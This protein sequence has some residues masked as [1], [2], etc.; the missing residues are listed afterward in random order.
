M[1]D[2]RGDDPTTS[3]TTRIDASCAA[4]ACC[5]RGSITGIPASRTRWTL[6]RPRSK[7]ND[8]RPPRRHYMITPATRSAARSACR[9][10]APAGLFVRC[11][12]RRLLSL[13]AHARHRGA[14]VGSRPEG[15]RPREV[16][17]LPRRRL[18]S[19]SL[20]ADVSQSGFSADDRARRG[21]DARLIARFSP[22]EIRRLAGLGQW[23]DPGRRRLPDR[24]PARAQRRSWSAISAICRRWARST[25]RPESGICATDFARLRQIAPEA[26]FRYTAIERG[27]G[28][29]VELPAEVG[30]DGAVCVRPRN[31]VA[32][33]CQ[34]Q[35][36]RAGG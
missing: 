10:F 7:D 30:D 20:E 31:V 13:A 2:T 29:T 12:L 28:Q 8:H 26:G 36:P 24:H 11:R 3:S 4:I 5:R 6:V 25:P 16:R 14:A 19:R 34:T 18:R 9:T 35:I 15:A 32:G 22:D 27:G 33:T 21:V 23:A 17:V 1:S